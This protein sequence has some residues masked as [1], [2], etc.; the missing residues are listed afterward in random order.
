MTEAARFL[1][2]KTPVVI[3]KPR[4]AARHMLHF[5]LYLA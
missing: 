4:N 5:R 1:I 2:A 3:A